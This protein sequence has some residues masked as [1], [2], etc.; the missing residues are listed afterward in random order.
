MLYAEIKEGCNRVYELLDRWEVRDGLS[1]LYHLVKTAED[2]EFSE[3]VGIAKQ[4]YEEL[5][6][7]RMETSL[8]GSGEK[9][10]FRTVLTNAYRLADAFQHK[11]FTKESPLFLL[12]RKESIDGITDFSGLHERIR[13]RP[14]FDEEAHNELFHRVFR[15]SFLT[16]QEA[17]D[18]SSI[19]QDTE[20]CRIAACQ[21]VS[22]TFLSI[23][24]CFDMRKLALLFVAAASSEQEIR[25]RGYT[26]LL[27]ALS[28]HRK[29]TAGYPELDE[30]L[31]QLAENDAD[32]V[33]MVILVIKRLTIERETE[34][35]ARRMS[36]E[37]LPEIVR[38]GKEQ[39]ESAI[40]AMS[41]EETHSEWTI[42]PG[43]WLMEQLGEMTKLQLEGADMMYTSFRGAKGLPFF[44]ELSRWFLPFIPEHPEVQRA[45][46]SQ[47]GD[48]SIA[49]DVETLVQFCN[50]DKY[51]FLLSLRGKPS[52]ESSSLIALMRESAENI[53]TFRQTQKK[54]SAWKRAE[55]IIGQYIPDLYR[56]YRLHPFRSELPDPFATVPTFHTLPVLQPHLQEKPPLLYLADYFLR[57]KLFAESLDI[58]RLYVSPFFDAL[59][60]KQEG[61]V[62]EQ[63]F[64]ESSEEKNMLIEKAG[65]CC[66][67][68]GEYQKALDYYLHAELGGENNVRLA[69]RIA[70]CY[71]RTGNPDLAI[72]YYRF[73]E[74][75]SPKDISL[76]MKVGSCLLEAEAYD[77]ALEYFYKADFYHSSLRTWRPLAWTLFLVGRP[78]DALRY[79]DNILKEQ[80][81]SPQDFLNAGH[82]ALAARRSMPEIVGHYRKALVESRSFDNFIKLFRA[83]IP[84]L[85]HAG[86]SDEE[87]SFHLDHLRFLR[88]HPL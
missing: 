84:H 42:T 61:S 27:M 35:I 77:K 21:T 79:Y 20:T 54:R 18:L 14:F 40:E 22:A 43:D 74:Q 45:L 78:E 75:A 32:F 48:L 19:L 6:C 62:Y 66:Q 8:D 33:R 87:L 10:L 36:E 59:K 71:R 63:A 67:M 82:A 64:F 55:Q 11:A 52:G 30:A 70:E 51:S 50:S 3:K 2:E 41:E 28:L 85:R 46:A 13:N 17:E 24:T 56:F 38:T 53:D 1:M 4:K 9:E 16:P 72:D 65:Y 15:S 47:G 12:N 29:R 44:A 86:L 73:C 68:M 31:R 88:R 81:P 60:K 58:F 83:D 7:A 23:Q 5:L 69:G 57:R 26:C 37:I 25:V 80:Q 49:H 34:E 76:L 39:I